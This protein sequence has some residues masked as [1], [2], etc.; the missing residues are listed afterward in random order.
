M[1]NC[2]TD[3][4]HRRL[5]VLWALIYKSPYYIESVPVR[6]TSWSVMIQSSVIFSTP[7]IHDE[8]VLNLA[9]SVPRCWMNY[10]SENCSR[11]FVQLAEKLIFLLI[12]WNCS[13]IFSLKKLRNNMKNIRA[14][15]SALVIFGHACVLIETKDISLLIDPVL[16]YTYESDVSAFYVRR[17]CRKKLIMCSSRT[18]I[19]TTSFWR[20]MLQLRHK[21][22]TLW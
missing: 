12:R 8:Q 6:C 10:L 7:R 4:H 18:A 20:T 17:T 13:E 3:R 21:I 11:N 1:W 5:Q 2:I 22:K 16:S 19:T 15:R 9:H 14:K